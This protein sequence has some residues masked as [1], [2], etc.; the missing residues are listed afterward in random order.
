MT[1]KKKNKIKVKEVDTFEDDEYLDRTL[2]NKNKTKE[3][4][5]EEEEK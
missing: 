5:K 2:G 1:K 4:K 3:D